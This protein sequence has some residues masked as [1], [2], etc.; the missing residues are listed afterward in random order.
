MPV[1]ASGCD[2]VSRND[3]REWSQHAACLD[4]DPELFFPLGSGEGALLQVEQARDVCRGCAVRGLCLDW[5]LETY[6]ADGVWGGM[7]EAERRN[8]KRRQSRERRD[9]PPPS[10]RSTSLGLGVLRGPKI[11]LDAM[12]ARMVALGLEPAEFLPFVEPGEGLDTYTFREI[13]NGRRRSMY[14]STLDKVAAVVGRAEAARAV[15]S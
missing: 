4:Q 9:G 12:R 15:R 8:L 10:G 6:Q 11:P 7:S 13:L 2:V 5:A 14:G 1:R 3:I